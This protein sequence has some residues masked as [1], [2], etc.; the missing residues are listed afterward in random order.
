MKGFNMT[1]IILKLKKHHFLISD[2]FL[3]IQGALI[4]IQVGC[5][6]TYYGGFSD[7]EI[8]RSLTILMSIPVCIAAILV[9][10]FA[11][12]YD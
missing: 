12:W 10:E 9:I 11:Y 1:N 6:I 4:L 5:G 3:Y 7:L 2:I 8:L